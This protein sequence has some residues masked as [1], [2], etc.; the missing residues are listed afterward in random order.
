MTKA[1]DQRSKSMKEQA[2]NEDTK[3]D[4]DH[5]SLTTKAISLISRRSVGEGSTHPVESYHIPTSAPSTSP[6]PI[7]SPSRRTIRQE[8]E[9]P[10]SSSP[11][12]TNVVDEVASTGVDVRYGGT[13]TTIT[14]LDV[15]QGNGN[16]DNNPTIHHDSPLLRF[17]TLRSDEG[18]MQ[19]NELIDLVIKLSNRVVALETELQ[20]TKKVYGIAFTKLIMKVKKLEKIVKSSKARRRAKIVVSDDEEDLEDPSK[21]GRMIDE[22]DQDP[23]I[24]LPVSTAGVAI[25]TASVTISTASPPRVSTADDISTAEKLVYIRR[26]ASKDKGKA[27]MD[28]YESVQTKTKLQQRQERLGYEA[29]LRLQ[30]QLDEEER[31][32][33]AKVCEEASSFNVEEW[34]AIQARVEADEELAHRLQAKEREKYS[35]AKKAKLLVELINQRKRYFSQQRAEERKNKPPMQAQ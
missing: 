6:P 19:Q 26:I 12:H 5:M 27:K 4:Q 24:T 22:I 14:S 32:R 11:P 16:I 18:I 9:V 25:T 13:A 21:Q 29:A 30:E 3:K 17:N 28:E 20:Q 34:E 7:S 15:G 2:Y 10:R 8:T 35:E 23:N 31:Q 33:I 1:Q